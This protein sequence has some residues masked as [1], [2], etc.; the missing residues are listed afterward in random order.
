MRTRRWIGIVREIADFLVDLFEIGQLVLGAAKRGD[1]GDGP[2][3]RTEDRVEVRD[4]LRLVAHDPAAD[5]R[6]DLHQAVGRQ[7]V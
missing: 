1:P 4:L 2:F 5:L 7:P 6:N 3:H